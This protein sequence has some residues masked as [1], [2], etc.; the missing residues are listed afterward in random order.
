MGSGRNRL[1]RHENENFTIESKDDNLNL[2]S[3]TK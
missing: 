1:S 3:D 2:L